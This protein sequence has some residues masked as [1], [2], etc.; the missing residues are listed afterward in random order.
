[1][2]M[3]C[4]ST[5]IPYC[6]LW[7]D[8]SRGS[9]QREARPWPRLHCVPPGLCVS[10]LGGS[11]VLNGQAG[12]TKLGKIAA[13]FIHDTVY[14]QQLITCCMFYLFG[15]LLAKVEHRDPHIGQLCLQ[16]TQWEE[17]C[18]HY[19]N[20]IG[21]CLLSRGTASHVRA[22]NPHFG[23][24]ACIFAVLLVLPFFRFHPLVE[25]G[26]WVWKGKNAIMPIFGLRFWEFPLHWESRGKQR[27]P[28]KR[29]KKSF[30]LSL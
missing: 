24:V 7:G 14:K 5:L 1:M 21:W 25:I 22:L 26:I 29:N 18:Q 3:K 27:N 17:N 10:Q 28:K 13:S 8:K 6:E 19:W 16:S 12:H 11:Q 4:V 2:V 20:E 15:S 23:E 9:S 30:L